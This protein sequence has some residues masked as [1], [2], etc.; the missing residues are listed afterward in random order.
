MQKI[1]STDNEKIKFLKKLGDKKVR[2]VSGQFLVENL[3]IIY[4]AMRAGFM[5]VQLFVAEDLLNKADEKINFIV[6]K[7]PEHFVINE[8]VNKY[9]S[10]LSTSSGIA[11]IFEKQEKKI[12]LKEKIIYLNA[13]NDPGNLGTILRTAVAFGL[14]NIIV[15]EKC[16]DVFNAKTISAAKD[17]IFKL[18][19]VKDENL[20]IFSEIKKVMLV[21]VTSLEGEVINSNIFQEEKFCLVLGNEANGVEEK[22]MKLSDKKVKISQSREIESLNVAVA[23]GILFEK[24]FNAK[25]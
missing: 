22:I 1:I 16:A 12:K 23:A 2:D 11:G 25:K 19:I 4:D 13:I 21:F 10:S 17:A 9:F 5:P 3:I 18:N 14:K 6:E 8:K 7:F 15:D 20:K 24:I